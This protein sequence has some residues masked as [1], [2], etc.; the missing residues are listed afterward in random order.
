MNIGEQHRTINIEPIE[1]PPPAED[2]VPI[3]E[4]MP[5]PRRDHDLEPA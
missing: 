5:D 4:P 2:P 1:E 3:A